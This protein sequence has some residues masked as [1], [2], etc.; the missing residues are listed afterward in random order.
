MR[1]QLLILRDAVERALLSWFRR[2]GGGVSPY[3]AR[4]ELSAHRPRNEK[5]IIATEKG[6]ALPKSRAV[7]SECHFATRLGLWM[8]A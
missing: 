8:Y 5:Y 4:R 1:E 7:Y 6:Y 3:R 2:I